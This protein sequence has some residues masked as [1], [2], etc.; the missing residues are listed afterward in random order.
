M[1]LIYRNLCVIESA[2]TYLIVAQ[3]TVALRGLVTTQLLNFPDAK[4]APRRHRVP[5]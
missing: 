2:G 4:D 3:K 5:R 1:S